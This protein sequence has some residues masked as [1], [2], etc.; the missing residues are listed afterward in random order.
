MKLR[1][2][3]HGDFFTLKSFSGKTPT[4]K[5]VYIKGDYDRS[6]RKY[7]C[8]R[9]DDISYSRLFKADTEIYTDFVY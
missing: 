7:D 4:D 2:L 6:S 9:A 3:K 1:E 5:Q 8:G